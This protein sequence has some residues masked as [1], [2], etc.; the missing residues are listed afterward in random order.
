YAGAGRRGRAERDGLLPRARRSG[1]RR[2]GSEKREEGGGDQPRDEGPFHGRGSVPAGRGSAN[3]ESPLATDPPAPRRAAAP[4][5][6]QEA[7]EERA[8]YARRSSS[9]SK[10]L[11]I[12]AG[13]LSPNL[14]RCSRTCVSSAFSASVST[15]SSVRRASGDRSSP[16]VFSA[17]SAGTRPIGVSLA[18][19]SPSQRRNTH[20]STREFSP[21]PGHRNFPSSSLRNQ[22]TLKTRGSRAP[23]RRPIASQWRK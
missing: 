4:E 6:A 14:A 8:H 5:D 20:S 23:S 11:R 13:R 10:C 7:P 15:L 16:S 3:P 17:P 22:L 1:G 18:S 12:D 21:K 19:A 9:A 2:G